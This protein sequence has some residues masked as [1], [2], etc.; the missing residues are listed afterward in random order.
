ML[1][2]LALCGAPNAAEYA[3]DIGSAQVFEK[4]VMTWHA[5]QPR[6]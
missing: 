2:G 6:P 4:G 1:G 5:G 3:T